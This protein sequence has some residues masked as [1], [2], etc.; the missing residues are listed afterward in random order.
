MKNSWIPNLYA[1]LSVTISCLKAGCALVS[2][3]L[4]LKVANYPTG[5]MH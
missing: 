2:V 5:V 1:L 4:T 3:T